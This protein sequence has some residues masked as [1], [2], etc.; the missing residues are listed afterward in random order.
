MN[1]ILDKARSAA[2]NAAKKLTNV[3][4][5]R[6][7]TAYPKKQKDL[8]NLGIRWDYDGE[9]EQ[10]G[11]LYNKF[12]IQP[13]AGKVDSTIRHW[14]EKHGGTHAV[15]G[16]MYV[17]KDG[18]VEDVAV[19][20]DNFAKEFKGSTSGEG[21]SSAGEAGG[22]GT[23]TGGS[24]SSEWVWWGD[25]GIWYRQINGV[26]EWYAPESGED[27]D[28]IYSNRQRKYFIKYANGAVVWQ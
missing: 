3:S 9:I 2:T 17:K 16:V 8:E 27:S 15:M 14:R 6:G 7:Q 21:S 5:S 18:S 4:V 25:E 19:G 20:W 12:Q 23:G 13:N 1:K 11:T 26:D 10:D 28:W 22:S 24:S